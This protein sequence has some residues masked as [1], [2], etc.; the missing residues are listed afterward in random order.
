VQ[1]TDFAPFATAAST[2]QIVA[3][4]NLIERLKEILRSTLNALPPKADIMRIVGEAY[5]KYV[6]PLDLP[7]VP[8]LLEPWADQ[9]LKAIVLQLASAAY[10]QIAAL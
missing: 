3:A 8:S 5:D 10:D 7:G 9:A 4:G 1:V 2:N 6:A